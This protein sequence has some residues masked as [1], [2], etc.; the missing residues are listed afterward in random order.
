MLRFVAG[1]WLV[2]L[3]CVPA[4][5]HDSIN[6]EARK[7]YLAKLQEMHA[8]LTPSATASVRAKSLYQIAVTLDE[9]SEEHTSELPVT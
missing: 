5:A 2:T 3:L 6:S 1:A 8:A 9:R 4:L 7:A